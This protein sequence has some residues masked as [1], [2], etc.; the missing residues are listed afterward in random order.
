MREEPFIFLFRGSLNGFV[1][2]ARLIY[3]KQEGS[4]R[5]GEHR[6]HSHFDAR[7][8]VKAGSAPSPPLSIP[9]HTHTHILSL[10]RKDNQV[11]VKCVCSFDSQEL[12]H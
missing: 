4:E 1:K 3:A 9:T 11:Y 6:L 7:C 8:P 5:A 12:A 2:T 10:P